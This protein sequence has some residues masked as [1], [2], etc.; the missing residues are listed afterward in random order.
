MCIPILL[1]GDQQSPSITTVWYA[2]SYCSC[3]AHVFLSYQ[4]YFHAKVRVKPS[5]SWK[6]TLPP[7]FPLPVIL[8]LSDACKFPQSFFK[9][10]PFTLVIGDPVETAGNKKVGIWMATFVSSDNAGGLQAYPHHPQQECLDLPAEHIVSFQ[11]RGNSSQ[12][13]PCATVKSYQPLIF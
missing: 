2:T 13:R 12:H 6:D 10:L 11:A 5:L 8:L 3:P 9:K 7:L 1:K 4:S